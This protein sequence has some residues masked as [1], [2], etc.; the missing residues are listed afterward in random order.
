MLKR[1]D[2]M[3]VADLEDYNNVFSTTVCTHAEQERAK[4]AYELARTSGYPSVNEL[5]QSLMTA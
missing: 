3:Y 5:M 2:G 1:R 4:T